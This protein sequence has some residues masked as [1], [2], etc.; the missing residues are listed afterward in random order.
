MKESRL[1]DITEWKSKLKDISRGMKK[2]Y[3]SSLGNPKFK[4]IAEK[5]GV[6][7]ATLLGTT[8]VGAIGG[9]IYSLCTKDYS[10]APVETGAKIGAMAEPF[11]ILGALVK[12]VEPCDPF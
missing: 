3:S 1:I 11:V 6:I 10:F 2:V 8:T 7:Y 5:T 12:N 4:K 9:A